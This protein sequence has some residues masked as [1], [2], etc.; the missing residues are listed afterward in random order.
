MCDVSTH[1]DKLMA[2]LGLVPSERS[3]GKQVRRG[4]ITKAGNPRVRR[5]PTED[6]WTYRYPARLSRPL[7]IRQERLPKAVREI[8]WKAQVRLCV[9]YRR[10]MATGK[11][12]IL[13]DNRDRT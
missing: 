8:A 13:G 2:Y 10:L 3:T 1:H 12:Q 5:A 4:N 6:T 9:R 7:Q 11:R